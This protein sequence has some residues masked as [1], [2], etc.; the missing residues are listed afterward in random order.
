MIAIGFVTGLEQ[1]PP[2]VPRLFLRPSPGGE[3]QPVIIAGRGGPDRPFELCFEVPPDPERAAEWR[4][5]LSES[6]A[7]LRLESF[8][9]DPAS[10]AATFGLPLEEALVRFGAGFWPGFHRSSTVF[11]IVGGGRRRGVY[12]A[13]RAWERAHAHVR[14]DTELDLDQAAQ[15]AQAARV[16]QKSLRRRGLAKI[17]RFS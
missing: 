6:I 1:C 14:F 16:A 17:F 4:P 7:G 9:L 15:A 5:R 10:I 13:V 3:A 11:L 2:G 8:C 12:Q